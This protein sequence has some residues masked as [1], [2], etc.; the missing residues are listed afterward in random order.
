MDSMFFI[1]L[2]RFFWIPCKFHDYRPLTVGEY[3]I[4]KRLINCAGKELNDW[5]F[6]SINCS[7]WARAYY[8]NHKER[9]TKAMVPSCE[10]SVKNGSKSF[11]LSGH[12]ELL[13]MKR[14]ILK[15]SK[16]E[17]SLGLWLCNPYF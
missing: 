1:V 10:T 3:Y 9:E 13:T 14:Y 12:R 15:T 16:Q 17:M 7:P 5:A 11:L 6:T 8:D 4:R 2:F